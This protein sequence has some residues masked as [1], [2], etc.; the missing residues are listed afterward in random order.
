MPLMTYRVVFNDSVRSIAGALP[1]LYVLAVRN[2][3]AYVAA[4]P[5]AEPSYQ[6]GT[7]ETERAVDTAHC[8]VSYLVHLESRTVEVTGISPLANADL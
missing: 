3:M 7:H 2:K 6:R 1:G 8:V 4:S 5:R